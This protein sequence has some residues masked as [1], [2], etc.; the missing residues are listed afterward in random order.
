MIDEA[1][2]K[3]HGLGDRDV[4]RPRLAV[5]PAFQLEVVRSVGEFHV[6][7][8]RL[9]SAS[10]AAVAL[11]HLQMPLG[12]GDV[13]PAGQ[14]PPFQAAA[15]R[16]LLPLQEAARGQVLQ[17]PH[18]GP[19]KAVVVAVVPGRRPGLSAQAAQG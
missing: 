6:P 3:R 9:V 7:D 12:D 5:P 13:V 15:A 18:R 11:A 8:P 17:L 16:P 2:Y 1:S 10:K 19:R 4:L 14:G